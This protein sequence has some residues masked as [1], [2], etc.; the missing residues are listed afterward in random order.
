MWELWV[1]CGGFD[2]ERKNEVNEMERLAEERKKEKEKR[3]EKR[4]NVGLSSKRE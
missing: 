1:V 3:A 2:Y 4:G